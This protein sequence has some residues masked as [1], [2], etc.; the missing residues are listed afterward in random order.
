MNDS[1]SIEA[2]SSRA[3]FR[4]VKVSTDRKIKSISSG[5]STCAVLSEGVPYIWG[6]LGKINYNIPTIVKF[7]DTRTDIF[8]IDVKVGDAFIVFLNSK[9]EVFTMG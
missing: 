6:K 3:E 9:G 2:Y 1:K 5:L 8:I 4:E 7:T